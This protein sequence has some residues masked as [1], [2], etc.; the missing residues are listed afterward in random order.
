MDLVRRRTHLDAVGVGLGFVDQYSD[1]PV[2]L[3]DDPSIRSILCVLARS[4]ASS[5]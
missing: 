1:P 3:A 4:A 2:P 5:A